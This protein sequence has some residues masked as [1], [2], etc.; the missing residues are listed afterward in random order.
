MQSPY[1]PGGDHTNGSGEHAAME[2]SENICG[3]IV[4]PI[5]TIT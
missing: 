5:Q 1:G 2:L 4:R 3:L